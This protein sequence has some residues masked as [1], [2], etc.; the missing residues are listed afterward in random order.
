MQQCSGRCDDRSGFLWSLD[1]GSSSDREC[2]RGGERKEGY[3]WRRSAY[4]TKVNS[5]AARLW[6]KNQATE[7]AKQG[8]KLLLLLCF[9]EGFSRRKATASHPKRDGDPQK[10]SLQ[11]PG[12][13]RT[14]DSPANATWSN[15]KE[16]QVQ[17]PPRPLLL[18]P[19]A[20]MDVLC[21]FAIFLG[22]WSLVSTFTEIL[23]IRYSKVLLLAEIDE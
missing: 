18:L 9:L 10:N 6:S 20:E 3:I 21:F 5:L 23:E 12:S 22:P 11:A 7:Q 2:S 19:L 8:S 16:Q 13:P 14:A 4:C 15:A 1:V 17:M